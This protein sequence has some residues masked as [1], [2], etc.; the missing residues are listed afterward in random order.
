LKQVVD[1]CSSMTTFDEGWSH[2][3][4]RFDHLKEFCVG[5]ATAFPGASV[6]SDFSIFN[7]EKDKKIAEISWEGIL[8]SK[9][10]D[11]IRLLGL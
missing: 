9:Q 10:F 7:W 5:L 11:M 3:T 8:H 6:E 4:N 1:K 2:V